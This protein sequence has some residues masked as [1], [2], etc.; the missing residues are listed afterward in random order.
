MS[1]TP[2]LERTSRVKLDPDS[3]HPVAVDLLVPSLRLVAKEGRRFFLGDRFVCLIDSHERVH[4]AASQ[5]PVY[6]PHPTESSPGS[7]K[8]QKSPRKPLCPHVK[9]AFAKGKLHPD[10]RTPREGV[11]GTFQSQLG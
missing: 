11:F 2:S 3:T 4:P 1:S 8:M 5:D 6:L 10:P 9:A 7:G